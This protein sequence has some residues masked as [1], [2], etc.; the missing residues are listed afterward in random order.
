MNLLDLYLPI[1]RVWQVYD[2]SLGVPRL[3]ADKLTIGEPTILDKSKWY[4]LHEIA[5][6][7]RK[8]Q[9]DSE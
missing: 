9:N 3:I 4:R 5:N 7:E 6:E 1:A 2:N 8:C